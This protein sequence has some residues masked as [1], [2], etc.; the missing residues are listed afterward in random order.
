HFNETFGFPSTY[1]SKFQGKPSKE[2][3]E[4]WARFAQHPMMDGRLGRMGVPFSAIARMEKA[5]DA[6]WLA[7]VVKLGDDKY[8]ANLD[9]FHNA[10]CLNM[11]RKMIYPEYYTSYAAAE[12][13]HLEHCLETLRQAIFCNSGT[14]LVTF[15]WVEGIEDPY[16]DY[17]VAHQCRDP[18]SMLHWALEN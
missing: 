3:D 14:G 13:G 8:M 18:E 6:D 2:V 17:N 1:P 15:H 11:L 7:S 10:H 12:R 9:L 5:A 4:E 16:P